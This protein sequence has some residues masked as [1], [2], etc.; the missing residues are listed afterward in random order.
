M[1]MFIGAIQA[2]AFSFAP[3]G[4][5]LCQGQVLPAAQYSALYGLIGNTYGGT[6]STSVGLPNFNG[7]TLISQDPSPSSRYHAG[8]VSGSETVTLTTTNMPQHAHGL[9]ATTSNATSP[10]PGGDMVLAAANGTDSSGDGITVNIYGPAPAQTALS[11]TAVGITGG[12]KPF[13]I[14]QPYLVASY[15]ICID[16]VM[17][18]RA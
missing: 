15:C 1:D 4:W 7:R 11:P 13:S 12:S 2:F 18:P 5:A 10:S 16:G 14:M 6:G 9:M 17:P 8:G 3:R